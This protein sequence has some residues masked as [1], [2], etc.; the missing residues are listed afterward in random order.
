MAVY[1]TCMGKKFLAKASDEAAVICQSDLLSSMR[2]ERK[3]F[4]EYLEQARA[5]WDRVKDEDDMFTAVLGRPENKAPE[6]ERQVTALDEAL[7][8]LTPLLA[9][10]FAKHI[11]FE[12]SDRGWMLCYN[13]AR[14]TPQG[15]QAQLVMALVA[16]L[17]DEEDL[18][19]RPASLGG[20]VDLAG[21]LQAE[22]P[23]ARAPVRLLAEQRPVGASTTPIG[24]DPSELAERKSAF[25]PA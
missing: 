7:A 3:L 17:M 25:H 18:D 23:V 21:R 19:K 14:A 20:L 22:M 10:F 6:Y 11:R 12:L 5:E 9:D 8:T 13:D 2:A 24:S 4:A 16:T 1:K 15:K